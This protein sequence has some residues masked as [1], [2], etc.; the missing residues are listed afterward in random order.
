MPIEEHKAILRDMDLRHKQKIDI[1]L[2][3]ISSEEEKKDKI[4]KL[5]IVSLE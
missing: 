5:Y 2:A 4:E 1:L 3:R